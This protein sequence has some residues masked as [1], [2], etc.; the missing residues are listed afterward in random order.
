MT[1][2]SSAGAPL[3]SAIVSL[4]WLLITRPF[5]SSS[6][7]CIVVTLPRHCGRIDSAHE[8]KIISVAQLIEKNQASSRQMLILQLSKK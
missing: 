8:S 3:E 7:D 5:P 4:F 1:N 6:I 2:L